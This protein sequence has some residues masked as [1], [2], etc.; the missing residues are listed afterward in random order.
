[1]KKLFTI[2]SLAAATS[3]SFSQSSIANGATCPDFTETDVY[4]VEQ[5]LYS[6][7]E[8][9]KYVILDFFA[10][11][12]GPCLVPSLHLHNFYTK[13]GCNEGDVIVIGIEGD[14]NSTLEQLQ[15]FKIDAG[16]PSSSFPS[17][18]GSAG[19]N[20]VRLQ[21]GVSAFPTIVLVGP[22]KK[23]INNDIW[24]IA[25]VETYE[26]AFPAGAITEMACSSASIDQNALEASL[27]LFPNPANNVLNISMNGIQN[28]AIAD[29]AGKSVFNATYS[30]LDNVEVAVSDLQVGIYLVSVTTAQGVVTKRFS[31]Q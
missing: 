15:Q 1:M 16:I 22:D 25:G 5:N 11:W 30:S 21:Y 26:N 19:G 12:C 9:G 20:D 24:P 13:Y 14:A 10:Y 23:M 27:N 4:G 17:V 3:F 8:D 31:K 18:L 7:C 28:I 2:F 6:Y 29:A